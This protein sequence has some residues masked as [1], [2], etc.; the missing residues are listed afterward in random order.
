MLLLTLTYSGSVNAF[1]FTDC[2]LKSASTSIIQQRQ[3]VSLS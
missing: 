2:G 3:V 1:L